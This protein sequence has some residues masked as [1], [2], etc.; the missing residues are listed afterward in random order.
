MR[1]I[2]KKSISLKAHLWMYFCTF[3]VAVMAMLWILQTLLLGVFYNSM[4]LNELKKAGKD[5]ITRYNLNDESFYDSW[6]E[7]S[8]NSGIFS[9]LITENGEEYGMKSNQIFIQ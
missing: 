3:A 6:F 9:Q 4:K 7:H 8:F 1:K 2:I 5:I